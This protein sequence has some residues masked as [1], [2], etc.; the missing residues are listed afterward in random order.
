MQR[1]EGELVFSATDL[2]NDLVCRHLTALERSVAAGERSRPEADPSV[3]LI[4]AKGEEHERAHLARL[5]LL[6]G[7][8]VVVFPERAAR[9][10]DELARAEAET[11]AAM[12]SGARVIYQASFFDGRFFGRADFLR[13]IDVA[14][15]RW[16]W[17]Y[18]VIDTKLALTPKPY[19]LIQLCNYSEHLTRLQG[20]APECGHIVLG[21]GLERRFRLADYAAYYRRQKRS[22]LARVAEPPQTYP[23]ECGHCAIC[24]WF[25]V[26]ETK[27]DADD[28]LGL[29]AW[30][31]GDQI[32]R[33]RNA[34]V[35][36][37]SELASASDAQRPFGMHAETFAKLRAQAALQHRQRQAEAAGVRGRARYFYELPDHE[38]GTGFELLFPPDAGD[39]FFDMEG[40]PLFAPDRAL[41]YLFGVYLPAEN[42]Y[43]RFRALAASEERGAFEEFID[44]LVSRLDRYPSM[45]VYHYAPYEPAALKRL[46]GRYGTREDALDNLLRRATFVDLYAVVRQAVRI[47]QPSYSIKMLEPFY[48]MTREGEIRRG[49]DSI[50]MFESWLVS[51]DAA[52]LEAIERY[53][54][55]DC[56]STYLLREWLLALRAERAR[57]IGR[58]PAWRREPE[59]AKPADAAARDALALRLL[60]GVPEPLSLGELRACDERT[61]GR[62]LLGH[63][64]EYHRREAKPAWWKIFHRAENVDELFEFDHEALARLRLREDVAAFKASP[65][66]RNL[67][68]TYDFPDQQ[69]NLGSGAPYCPYALRTAGTIHALDADA[70]RIQLKLAGGLA[71]E[72]IRALIPGGPLPTGVQQA[73]LHD[74]AA[75][76]LDGTLAERHPAVCDL[77]LARTP[78][79]RDRAWGLP[80]QPERVTPEAVSAIVAQLDASYLFIQGPPGSGKST[81]GAQVIADLLIAGQRVGVLSRSHKAIHHLIGKVESELLRRRQRFAGLYKASDDEDSRYPASPGGMVANRGDNAAFWSEPH[82]LAGGTSWLFARPELVG[83][84]DYLFVDEAGQLALADVLACARSARNVVLLGDPLQLA[85]VSQGAHPVGTGLSILEHLLGEHATIPPERGIFL[86]VSYRMQPEICSFI[87]ATVYEGR[88]RADPS[89][90]RNRVDTASLRGGGLRFVR[91]E[92]HGNVRESPEEAAEIVA[93]VAGL[94]GGEVT[95][96]T[97]A[98][99]S[100]TQDDV[101]VVTPYN[102]QRKLIAGR[103]AAAGFPAIRVGTVDKFQGQEAPVVFY[104]MATSSGE[105]VPRT[106]EFLFEKNRLNVA[107][108]R[109]QCLSV[110]VCSLRL[111]DAACATPEQMAL[112]NLLCSFAEAA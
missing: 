31:R 85:Q 74:V 24:R 110:L 15:P 72:G 42:A 2:N 39:V 77:L 112:V 91:C 64:L 37:I 60:E 57:D 48:G 97:A 43:R 102:A 33:L 106:L 70:N 71:P 108:S 90:A 89:T 75:A 67:V 23:S 21:S 25:R 54:E 30:M 92:H 46:A 80:I 22:F 73:A 78:R 49:D 95:R 109:A 9:T 82:D 55:D 94:M 34:E 41:E 104:S 93:L 63:L 47:S 53:N 52:I 79:L 66:D 88:L 26:C 86:D 99:R 81:T 87:S 32:D 3:E 19:F 59:P 107:I 51:R 58:E 111:L 100:L 105:D 18:E 40:D 7:D 83:S 45:H 5:Q 38:N 56:R 28:Y 98:P 20:S 29:V 44:F 16:P 69:Y 62:W 8:G 14:S 13:R 1:I 12:A 4:A 35:I 11:L 36:T 103:L 96:G 17:S 68:Y 10:L 76:F 27:R 6:H 61:R 65:S 101:L 50:V 84:Y